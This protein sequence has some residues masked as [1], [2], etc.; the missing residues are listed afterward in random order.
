MTPL[1]VP[2]VGLRQVSVTAVEVDVALAALT[3]EGGVLFTL[4]DE[5]GAVTALARQISDSNAPIPTPADLVAPFP[6]S[7]IMGEN[8]LN[9]FIL[10]RA[11]SRFT[12]RFS[13]NHRP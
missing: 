7:D 3:W 12:M 1:K 10:R 6:L 5:G 2:G 9:L 8:Y 11:L 4:A 13:E